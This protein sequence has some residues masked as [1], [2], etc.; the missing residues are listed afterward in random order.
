MFARIVSFDD[1]VFRTEPSDLLDLLHGLYRALDELI[2]AF[3]NVEKIE[4]AG[5]T[6][7]CAAGAPETDPQHAAHLAEYALAITKL[8]ATDPRFALPDGTRA[9]FKI[10]LHCGPAVGGVVGSVTVM[11]KLFGDTVNTASRMCSYSEQ[12]CVHTSDHFAAALRGRDEFIVVRIPPRMIK[13]KGMMA[14]AFVYNDQTLRLALQAGGAP[15]A[16]ARR[17]LLQRQSSI[18]ASSA[19]SHRFSA[20]SGWDDG[21]ATQASVLR[22]PLGEGDRPSVA[23]YDSDSASRVSRRTFAEGSVPALGRRF[24]SEDIDAAEAS[25]A[26]L[27]ACVRCVLPSMI[28]AAQRLPSPSFLTRASSRAGA[29]PSQRSQ[30]LPQSLTRRRRR[31]IA[32]RAL[33]Q[34]GSSRCFRRRC[35]SSWIRARWRFVITTMK[36]TLSDC[37]GDA[38][39]SLASPHAAVDHHATR[40]QGSTPVAP[41]C[42]ARAGAAGGDDAVFRC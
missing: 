5:D 21:A 12:Q 9:V 15:A 1:I 16:T 19:G 35:T 31:R 37:A 41:P 29:P 40:A 23:G 8:S 22:A 2:E 26:T 11:Y 18:S 30:G 36:L 32:A 33:A 27:G 42:S 10:G 14:C 25:V 17:A 4:A 24:S 13:G 20:G 28:A 38:S 6:Y 34:R 3:P 39:P 7:I